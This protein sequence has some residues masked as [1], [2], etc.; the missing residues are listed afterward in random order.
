[1]TVA[2]IGCMDRRLNGFF[3]DLRND[4]IQKNPGEKVY[5]VRDAGGGVGTVEKTVFD[6]GIT[7][8]HDYTHTNCGAMKV[9]LNACVKL[10]SGEKLDEIESSDDV[11]D[12]TIAPFLNETYETSL[13]IEE[14]NTKIQ[15][16]TLNHLKI[17]HP[18]LKI[19]CEMVD[20][21]KLNVPKVEGE[22]TLVIGMAY[23]GEYSEIA[24][25]YNLELPHVYFVQANYLDEIRASVK[26]AVEKLNIHNIIFISNQQSEDDTVERWSNDPSLKRLFEKHLIHPPIKTQTPKK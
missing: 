10:N 23:C 20:V 13:A 9:A 4:I 8:I 15:N 1:M 16:D 21:E 25:K 24:S 7:E 3:D 18:D 14:K 19:S 26:L 2:I 5:I 11:Y 6:L 12:T 22:H 17:N